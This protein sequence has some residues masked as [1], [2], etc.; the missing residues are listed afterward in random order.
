MNSQGGG[1]GE[2]RCIWRE[3]WRPTSP[4]EMFAGSNSAVIA[5]STGPDSAGYL[6]ISVCIDFTGITHMVKVMP[7]FK[8]SALLRPLLASTGAFLA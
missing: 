5:R 4:L 3:E 6:R 2:A 7:V 1:L 8:Y